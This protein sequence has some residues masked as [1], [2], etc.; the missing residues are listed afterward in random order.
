VT[1]LVQ[2]EQLGHQFGRSFVHRKDAWW[3]GFGRSKV[4]DALGVALLVPAFPRLPLTGR[5]TRTPSIA[6]C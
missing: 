6:M 3:T 4:A 2:P 1:V 5:C